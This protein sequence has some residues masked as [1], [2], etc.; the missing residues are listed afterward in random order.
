[1][2]NCPLPPFGDYLSRPERFT[3][4]KVPKRKR[5]RS[6]K[7]LVR[8]SVRNVKHPKGLLG[9]FPARV[10]VPLPGKVYFR[11]SFPPVKE[12]LLEVTR[13][14]PCL[15]V[16]YVDG[17]CRGLDIDRGPYPRRPRSCDRT[18]RVTPRKRKKAPAFYAQARKTFWELTC[19]L[20]PVQKVLKQP[21]SGWLSRHTCPA[22]QLRMKIEDLKR[23]QNPTRYWTLGLR[24]GYNLWYH[25]GCNDTRPP[26][27]YFKRHDVSMK[28]LREVLTKC[29]SLLHAPSGVTPEGTQRP[30]FRRRSP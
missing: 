11:T 8:K 18:T 26:K 12:T 30:A 13:S 10:A 19:R 27:Y 21:S 29:K 4:K 22:W 5:K 25:Y 20:S 9:I 28:Y 15:K 14:N 2:S 7:G 3:E 23:L 6:R 17:L 1:M 24:I 16:V